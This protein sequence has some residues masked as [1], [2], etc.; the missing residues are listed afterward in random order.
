MLSFLQ[1]AWRAGLLTPEEKEAAGETYGSF[2][3]PKM[4][5]Q[6]SWKGTIYTAMLGQ[7]DTDFNSKTTGL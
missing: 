1:Q 2:P 7:E 3:V 5:L 6:E 4:D